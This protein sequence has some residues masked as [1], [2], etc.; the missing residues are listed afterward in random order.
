[1]SRPAFRFG[2][3]QRGFSLLELLVAFSILAMS[4][5]ML[6]RVSGNNIRLVAS[7][8]QQDQALVLAESLL[9]SADSVPEAGWADQGNSAGFAWR[10]Y[11]TPYRGGATEPQAVRLHQVWIQIEWPANGQTKQITLS[12]LLPQRKS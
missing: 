3:K 9:S 12:T 6:Y 10:I 11:T 1:M 8:T 4:L 2:N 5:G 7:A